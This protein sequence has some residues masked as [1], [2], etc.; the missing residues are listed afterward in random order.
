MTEHLERSAIE[1]PVMRWPG[2]DGSVT[3]LDSGVQ[4]QLLRGPSHWAQVDH[5]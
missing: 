1:D 5:D 2:P 4:L 3:S